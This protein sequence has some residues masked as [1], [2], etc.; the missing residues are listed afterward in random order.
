[1]KMVY[2]EK[3]TQKYAR[4]KIKLYTMLQI[5]PDILY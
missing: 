1:M 2:I 5:N 4:R 3:C